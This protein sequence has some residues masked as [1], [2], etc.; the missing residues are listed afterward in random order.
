MMPELLLQARDRLANAAAALLKRPPYQDR[1]RAV[2][3]RHA[4]RR[5][6][7][8]VG[9]MWNVD[10][11]YAFWALENGASEVT[12]LDVRDPTEACNAEN[13]RRGSRV[14]FVTGD[15][16]DPTL[17]ERLGAFDVVFCSG[18]LYHMPDPHQTLVRLRDICTRFL[19]LGSAV[20]P[21]LSVPQ[22]AVFYPYI[23]ERHRRRLAYRTPTT[24]VGLDTPYRPEWDYSNYYWGLTVSCIE[25][26]VRVVGFVPRERYTWRHALC[27]VC[28]RA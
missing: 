1:L 7:I 27:L 4:P 13:L 19:I 23:P 24:K 18:V 5:T 12:G 28:E 3:A 6:F 14:R 2:I 21:E 10:G 20:I 22:G 8:D 11:A 26:M 25:A 9:C 15:I 16:N 17:A